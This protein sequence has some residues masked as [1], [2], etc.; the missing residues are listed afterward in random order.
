MARP[1]DPRLLARL[2]GLDHGPSAPVVARDKALPGAEASRVLV[3]VEGISD[4]MAVETL[5]ARLGRDLGAEGVA[6]LPIGGSGEARKV[7]ARFAAEDRRIVGLLDADAS[8]IFRRALAGVGIGDAGDS[9]EAR[10]F[11]TCQPTLEV[12]L[13][14]ALGTDGFMALV[15]R[16]GDLA[17][18]RTLQ[19]Q[20]AWT[21][22]P[23]EAQLNRFLRAKARR[24]MIYAGLMV[25]ACPLDRMPAPLMG[26]LRAI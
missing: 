5:A 9:L 3:V 14:R 17:P 1:T 6:I 4:R 11:F 2:A 8:G 24:S 21:A 15:E 16:A 23:L 18:L 10:G 25:D 19:R 12:E 26:V 13:I 20:A 22:R 7:L